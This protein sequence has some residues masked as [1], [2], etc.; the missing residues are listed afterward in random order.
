[1]FN[2]LSWTPYKDLERGLWLI[3]FL[4][5]IFKSAAKSFWLKICQKPCKGPMHDGKAIFVFLHNF[6]IMTEM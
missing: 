1:M 3:L 4:W 5:S 2:V 6:A